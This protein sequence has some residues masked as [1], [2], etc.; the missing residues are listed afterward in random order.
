MNQIAEAASSSLELEEILYLSLDRL[1]A[2]LNLEA[3][4]VHLLEPSSYDL[5]LVAHRGV[6]PRALDG[7]LRLH[8]GEGF[9]GLVA[10][11]GEPVVGSNFHAVH[12]ERHDDGPVGPA[13]EC[14]SFA[15]VPLTDRNR[16]VGVM[17]LVS[18][19]E[20]PFTQHDLDLLLAAG[21]SVGVAVEHARLWRL[22]VRRAHDLEALHAVSSA[23]KSTVGRPNLLQLASEALS[24]VLGLKRAI[25]YLL[26]PEQSEL[27]PVAGVNVQ[28]ATQTEPLKVDD[29]LVARR[30]IDSRRAIYDPDPVAS[31]LFSRKEADRFRVTGV[32]VV[33]IVSGDRPLGVLGGDWGGDFV[34]PAADDLALAESLANQVAAALENARLQESARELAVLEERNRLAREIHDTI[35]QGLT[36][37]SLQLEAASSLLSQD[38]ARAGRNITRALSLV[39]ASLEEARRSVLDLRPAPLQGL[40]LAEALSVLLNDLAAECGWAARLDVLRFGGRLSPRYE[41]GLYRIAQEAL[42]NVQKHAAATAVRLTVDESDTE[43]VMT[44]TPEGIELAANITG[45]GIDDAHVEQAVQ[46]LLT[47]PGLARVHW[48]A[49]ED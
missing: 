8:V 30:A 44:R 48:S 17:S 5:R 39:R 26:D 47:E 35:V 34:Q 14:R 33:P 43:I 25:V 27:H 32:L 49:V 46:H 20:R 18:F 36:A 22:S 41:V 23:L 19:H 10:E 12:Q 31:G 4:W 3:G 29:W 45:E 11:T 9:A 37:V 6:A 2:L 1:L 13:A 28:V 16:V 40:T 21:R 24:N 42:T 38:P 7:A 15:A